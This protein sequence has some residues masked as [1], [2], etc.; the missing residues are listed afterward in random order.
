[1]NGEPLPRQGLAVLEPRPAHCPGWDAHPASQLLGHIGGVAPSLLHPQPEVFS[2]SLKLQVQHL[3]DDEVLGLHLEMPTAW[4]VPPD[5][6]TSHGSEEERSIVACA[7]IP[8]IH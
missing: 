5:P 8:S 2:L 4:W 1:M 6:R 3:L 7:T